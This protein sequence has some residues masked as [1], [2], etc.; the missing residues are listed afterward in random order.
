MN[1]TGVPL[2]DDLIYKHLHKSCMNDVCHE[3]GLIQREKELKFEQFFNSHI[4]PMIEEY[5]LHYVPHDEV[6]DMTE[7]FMENYD[8]S[9]MF[10][11]DLFLTHEYVHDLALDFM[12]DIMQNGGNDLLLDN[13][14]RVPN[15]GFYFFM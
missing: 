9:T 8:I 14:I 12:Y 4:I 3:L 6:C 10:P 2:V 15:T 7:W 1:L 11:F 5:D 13:Y